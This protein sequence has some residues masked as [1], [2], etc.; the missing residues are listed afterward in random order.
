MLF[1][2]FFCRFLKWKFFSD[3]IIEYPIA[4]K[5]C[6]DVLN[7]FLYILSYYNLYLYVCWPLVYHS[8]VSNMLRRIKT[9]SK[10][11][12]CKDINNFFFKIC[13]REKN[14]LKP[15]KIYD[16]VIW[17]SSY[18][19]FFC[20]FFFQYFSSVCFLLIFNVF[21]IPIHITQVWH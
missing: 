11:S 20:L 13:S 8:C 7:I 17:L 21:C 6:V 1:P 12:W 10:I 2:N 5:I 14:D 16:V 4:M 18:S 19:S 3:T 9:V 15:I